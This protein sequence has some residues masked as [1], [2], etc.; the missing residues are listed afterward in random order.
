MESESKIGRRRGRVDTIIVAAYRRGARYLRQRE[1][2]AAQLPLPD[3]RPCW[4][5]KDPQGKRIARMLANRLGI[6]EEEV[7]ADAK[8]AN[9]VETILGNCGTS[10]RSVLFSGQLTRKQ[11]ESVNRVHPERQRYELDVVAMGG[12]LFQKPKNGPPPFDTLGF[13]EVT[14]RLARAEGIVQQA[15][16]RIRRCSRLKIKEAVRTRLLTCLAEVGSAVEQ[17]RLLASRGSKLPAR[18]PIKAPDRGTRTAGMRIVEGDLRLQP[19]RLALAGGLIRKNVRD[20][21]RL[22]TEQTPT[23]EQILAIHHYVETISTQV[24]AAQRLLDDRGEG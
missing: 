24:V 7:R 23:D 9:A 6:D 12:R 3:G 19:G 16:E 13:Y 10:Y 4:F 1:K 22:A 8:F 18:H 5:S 14:S 15:L 20:L 17:L 21:P 2:V 11:I